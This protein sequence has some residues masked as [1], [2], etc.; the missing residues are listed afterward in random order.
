MASLVFWDGRQVYQGGRW[1]S[2]AGCGALNVQ[3][4]VFYNTALFI[5]GKQDF[6]NDTPAIFI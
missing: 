3:A 5:C 2:L 1:D 4:V 6:F